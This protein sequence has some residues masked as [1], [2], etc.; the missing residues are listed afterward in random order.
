MWTRSQYYVAQDGD[1]VSIFRGVQVDVPVLKLSEVYE[2][3]DFAVSDLPTGYQEQVQEG[4]VADDLSDAQR[5]L[6]VLAA[7][8]AGAGGSTA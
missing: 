6:D 3:G 1:T 7:Q 2:Q 8:A 5:I 4:I